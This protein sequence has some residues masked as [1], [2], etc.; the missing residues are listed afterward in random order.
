[1]DC[2][3]AVLRK[4][5]WN[6]ILIWKMGSGIDVTWPHISDQNEISN[7][8]LWES[9]RLLKRLKLTGLQG[10]SVW[11]FFHIMLVLSRVCCI[12]IG[13]RTTEFFFEIPTLLS[14][15]W[16]NPAENGAR[17]FNIY[18]ILNFPALDFLVRKIKEWEFQ[19][20]FCRSGTKNMYVNK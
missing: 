18:V 6:F 13:Q 17:K 20:N 12:N 10:F 1:M 7:F 14:Y 3:K 16:G 8:Y 9:I 15:K 19:K 4:K 11:F 5:I 2:F